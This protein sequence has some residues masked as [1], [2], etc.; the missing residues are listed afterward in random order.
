MYRL[1]EP[2]ILVTEAKG[3]EVFDHSGRLMVRLEVLA[4][5]DVSILQL[6]VG[7]DVLPPRS[8]AALEAMLKKH[9][10]RL[11]YR[12]MRARRDIARGKGTKWAWE[13][14]GEFLGFTW[15]RSA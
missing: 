3:R 11:F 15:E 8:I 4:R 12:A 7:C 6:R 5:G 1:R 13:A 14:V 9:G 10:W 2:V